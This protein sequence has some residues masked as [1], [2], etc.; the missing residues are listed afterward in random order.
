MRLLDADESV[1]TLT[2]RA[3]SAGLA[4]LAAAA[5]VAWAA[6]V[7]AYQRP[8]AIETALIASGQL[9][10]V[11]LATIVVLLW[12]LRRAGVPKETISLGAFVS[13]GAWLAP[14]AVLCL[15]RS[16][17]S[18]PAAAAFAVLTAVAFRAL[19]REGVPDDPEPAA[20][21]LLP[22]KR[23]DARRALGA[24]T[25]SCLAYV[26]MLLGLTVSI[27][28]AALLVGSAFAVVAWF[29]LTP[30]VKIRAHDK[31]STGMAL[32]SLIL[33]T[34]IPVAS[35]YGSGGYQAEADALKQP[36][37]GLH[38]GVVLMTTAKSELQLTAPPSPKH[39]DS[40]QPS[41]ISPLSIPFTGE[42]WIF[43]WPRR[44]PGAEASRVYGSPLSAAYRSTD[45]D[46]FIMEA[47][48]P[49]A[50]AIDTDCCRAIDVVFDSRDPQPEN[51]LLELL[52][53]DSSGLESLR[54]SLG[55]VALHSTGEGAVR[56]DTAPAAGLPS[57]D[58][59]L[60]RFHLEQ[61]RELHS[62]RV[63]I[64]RFDLVP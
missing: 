40:T 12:R 60:V 28:L 54:R 50:T 10:L 15:D 30:G 20:P 32:V 2:Q 36:G 35:T 51:V 64:K 41:R 43:Y 34:L 13:A 17:L 38:T 25:A 7:F 45:G 22:V 26:G 8:G 29:R 57:F 3:T 18:L 58:E 24:K 27:P 62:A 44:R 14:L 19:P 53:V 42:Y 11:V 39:S 52:L 23:Q 31:T 33:A 59:I 4:C 6:A 1:A 37:N 56:F 49:L 16:W 9:G 61:P 55:A 5:L 48:Q 46:S 63:A 21:F 47:H